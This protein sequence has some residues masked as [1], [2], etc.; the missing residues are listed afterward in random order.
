MPADGPYDRGIGE[1]GDLL[2]LLHGARSRVRTVR[3]TV[4]VWR[5][6]ERFQAA[7]DRTGAASFAPLGG[8]QPA[9]FESRTRVWLAAP[10]HVRAEHE[11]TDGTRVGVQRGRTWWQY[12]EVNGAISNE[13]DPST[14]AGVGEEIR[15]LLDAGALTGLLDFERLGPGVRGGREA[16]RVRGVPRTLGRHE[17]WALIGIGAVGADE[18]LL[19]VD[20][21]RGILLR[22]EARRDG[23]PF[24]IVELLEVTFDEAFPEET[25]VFTPPPGVQVRST[26]EHG[27]VA[28]DLTVEQAAAAAPVVLWVPAED[29]EVVVAYARMEDEPPMAPQVHLQY[30][31]AGVR[32]AQ[33]PASHPDAMSGFVFDGAGPWREVER[34]GRRIEIQEHADDRRPA[35][36]RLD[37]EGT[38]VVIPSAVFGAEALADV[39]AGLRR[40]T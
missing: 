40:A 34:R 4:R 8:S 16:I 26:L 9:E 39:A 10:D 29:W 37:L 7:I 17:P 1:L 24:S 36:V 15:P 5:D 12:D 13:N 20:A 2:E 33:S 18:L 31:G 21:E 32:I 11:G 19:D 6:A 27:P 3:G 35:Q 25:F 23:E 28:F 38:R 22:V 14:E 30:V